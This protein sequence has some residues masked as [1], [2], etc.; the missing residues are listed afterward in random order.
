MLI[1]TA[2]IA[3]VSEIENK[4][5]VRL[6]LS[7]LK[8]WELISG[9]SVVQ[10]FVGIVAVLITLACAS[11]LGFNVGDHTGFLILIASLASISMIAFSLIVAGITKSANEILVVGNFPLFLFMFFTGAVFPISST[12][13]FSFME[14]DFQLHALMSP[15]H[16]ISALNKVLVLGSPVKSTLP[17]I[18]CLIGLTIIYYLV[19]MYIFGR[20]HLRSNTI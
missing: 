4:T 13:L 10:I 18:I 5:I 7:G 16:A 19:G 11:L 1:L 17:E 15:T 6:K 2:A 12:T 20:R 14:Y 9:I 3:F 8:T